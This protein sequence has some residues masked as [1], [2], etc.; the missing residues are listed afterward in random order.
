MQKHR[1]Q[2]DLTPEALEELDALKDAVGAAT[3]AELLRNAL[4][5]YAWFMEKRQEGYDLELRKGKDVKEVE[6]LV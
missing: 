1:L 3:R 6:V 5:L 4:R 2:F